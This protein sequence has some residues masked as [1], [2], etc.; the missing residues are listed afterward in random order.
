MQHTRGLWIAVALFS[1]CFAVAAAPPVND[2]FNNRIILDGA[3]ITATGSNANASKQ[4][5]EPNH[6]GNPG[7]RSVWWA[8][9]APTNGDLTITSDASAFDTLLAVYTGSSVSSL[10]LVASNDDHGVLVTSRVRFYAS[11]GTQYQIAVDGFNDGTGAESGNVSLAVN[12]IPEPITRPENDIFSNRTVLAGAPISVISSNTNATREPGEPLHAGQEGDTSLWWRWTA[13]SNDTVRVTTA[14]SS[15]DTLLGIYTGSSVSNLTEIASDDDEDTV[16]GIVTSAV[17]LNVVAGQEYQI[18]V[19]GYD[20]ASGQVVLGIESVVPRL[21][22]PEWS[23]GVFQFT[24]NGAGGT[25]NEIEAS[26]DQ[27]SWTAVGTLVMTNGTAMFEET[28]AT[29]QSQRF[30]RATLR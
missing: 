14:G 12:L 18:A 20:G 24:V 1:L 26:E 11:A 23:N 29:N 13:S 3:N 10:S 28:R 21:T 15:F 8:W 25:T 27:R 30:Y 17:I 22:A 4:N 6:A 16:N 9:T 7:G 2:S 19:D 5:G